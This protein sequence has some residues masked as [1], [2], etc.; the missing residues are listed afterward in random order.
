MM[1]NGLGLSAAQKTI[2]SYPTRSDY[3]KRLGDAYN[4]N[5]MTPTV[6]RLFR[7]WLRSVL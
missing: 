4:R 7:W 1:S 5:R 3:L 6:A 2:F